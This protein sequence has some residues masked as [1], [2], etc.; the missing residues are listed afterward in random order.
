[1]VFKPNG[2]VGIGTTAPSQ[3]LEIYTA[4]PSSMQ[5][6]NSSDVLGS[7]GAVRFNMAGTEVGT[8]ESERTIATGRQSALKF[9]VRDDAGLIEAMRIIDNGNIGIGTTNPGSYKLAVAGT[10]AARRVKVTQETWADY[11]FHE[12]YQLPAL[13]NVEKYIKENHHLPQ[14][15]SAAEVQKEGLDLGEMNK[16]LLQKV[17]ELTLYIIQQQKTIENQEKRLQVLERKD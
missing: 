16:K 8:I 9:S 10:V 13:S 12:G 11:V 5:L 6:T 17:E 1:M 7:V 14:I 15:P 2:N 3:R 4:G